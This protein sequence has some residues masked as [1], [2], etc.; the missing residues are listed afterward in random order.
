MGVRLRGRWEGTVGGTAEA[1]GGKL[2]SDA[3]N[4]LLLKTAADSAGRKVLRRKRTNATTNTAKADNTA[5]SN[6]ANPHQRS[7]PS[8]NNTAADSDSTSTAASAV[9]RSHLLCPL[10]FLFEASP[11][12]R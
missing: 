8:S 11:L 7:D 9:Q 12:D 2:P 3:A 10:L 6:W 1:R 5:S 4:A